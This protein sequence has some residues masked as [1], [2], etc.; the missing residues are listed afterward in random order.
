MMRE[1]PGVATF[2]HASL[3]L[4]VFATGDPQQ[5]RHGMDEG[6]F[7][8]WAG[9]GFKLSFWRPLS[10]ATHFLDH[11]LTGRPDG[12]RRVVQAPP[13][14]PLVRG[15]APGRGGSLPRSRAAGAI[16]RSG[17]LPRNPRGAAATRGCEPA[18]RRPLRIVDELREM[19]RAEPAAVSE[20]VD[21]G[22]AN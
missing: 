3:D 8:W 17:I 22:L 19:W 10:A 2:P 18:C 21:H 9:P 11:V 7:A 1:D 6:V 13:Q 16:H 12:E 14:R 5:F 20:Q 4:F 15:P